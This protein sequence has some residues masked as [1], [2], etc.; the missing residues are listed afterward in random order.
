MTPARRFTHE[1]RILTFVAA[2][3]ITGAGLTRLVVTQVDE[4]RRRR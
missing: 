3:R 1:I 2:L 4:D